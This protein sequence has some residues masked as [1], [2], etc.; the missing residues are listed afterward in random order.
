MSAQEAE[1]LRA[2]MDMAAVL[3]GLRAEIERAIRMVEACDPIVFD[4]LGLDA[5]AC[6]LNEAEGA[7]GSA[8]RRVE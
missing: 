1:A 6:G 5:V 2:A 7:I 4:A 8:L 3:R